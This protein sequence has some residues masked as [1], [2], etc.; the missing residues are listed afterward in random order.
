MVPSLPFHG[1]RPSDPFGIALI[2]AVILHALVL[3]GVSFDLPHYAPPNP[4]RTLDISLI[5]TQTTKS[6]P[7]DPDFLAQQSSAGGA[8]EF[9]KERP[10][11]QPSLPAVVPETR[12]AIE[13]QRAGAPEPKPVAEKAV[14]TTRES[15]RRVEQH[16]LE[17]TVRS[18]QQLDV[19]QLLDRSRRDIEQ[20]SL[21]LDQQSRMSSRTQ[22]RRAI[23][24]S[25]QEYKYAAYLEAWRKKVERIGN[26][27]YPDEAK[28]KKLY[29]NLL[30]HVPVKADGS[31]E[32]DEVRIVRSSG[33]KILD[34]AAI[35]I[36]KL[37]A[38]FAPFP[39]EIRKEVDVLDI[40]RTWQFL[41]NNRLFSA[42]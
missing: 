13:E 23:N 30:L 29:G 21:E 8:P 3:F 5:P 24:A 28:R 12:P 33:H 41:S 20:L 17:K 18:P 15:P 25:T 31:I 4:E 11:A 14:L 39:P 37:A 27:N 38:P 36:V 10:A 22:R 6:K 2:I 16:K 34:D 19:A 26:L 40:T 35:R 1:K 9:D 42:N 7:E 32:G